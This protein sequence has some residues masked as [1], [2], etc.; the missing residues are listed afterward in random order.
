MTKYIKEYIKK[1]ENKLK[2]DI[3]LKDIEELKEYYYSH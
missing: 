2:K 3:T 1:M